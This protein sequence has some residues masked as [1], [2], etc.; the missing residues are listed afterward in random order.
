MSYI[1]D[2]FFCLFS[3]TNPFFVN[4][5]ENTLS[6]STMYITHDSS[7]TTILFECSK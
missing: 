4:F 2:Y 7:I 3:V 5:H 6:T 1:L